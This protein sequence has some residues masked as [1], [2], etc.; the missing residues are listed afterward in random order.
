[1]NASTVNPYI[2]PDR[3]P[4]YE[5]GFGIENIGYENH[6]LFRVDFNWRNNYLDYSNARRFGIKL[7]I[8]LSF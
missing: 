2:V 6:R 8:N 1:M 5:Y 4:Y 3:T 7:S